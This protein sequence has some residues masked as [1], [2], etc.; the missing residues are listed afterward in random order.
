ML[1]II[2]LTY[3]KHKMYGRAEYLDERASDLSDYAVLVSCLPHH[4]PHL[5]QRLRQTI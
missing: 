4:T 5:T 1:E 3:I 2:I